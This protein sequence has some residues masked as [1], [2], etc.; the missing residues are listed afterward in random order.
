M[1]SSQHLEEEC[2]R[3]SGTEK[4]AEPYWPPDRRKTRK[5]RFFDVNDDPKAREMKKNQTTVSRWGSSSALSG[6]RAQKKK[7]FCCIVARESLQSDCRDVA[8]SGQRGK[9][10]TGQ[11]FAVADGKDQLVASPS[12]GARAQVVRS[13]EGEENS[14]QGRNRC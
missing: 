1:K 11:W 3:R 14:N 13:I 7:S 4:G 6:F 8:A 5:K 12:P 2:E 10:V 9:L